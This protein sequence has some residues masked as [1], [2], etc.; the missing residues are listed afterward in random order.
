MDELKKLYE[1]NKKIIKTTA[2]VVIVISAMIWGD[3][4]NV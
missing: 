4:S 3:A 2:V 1:E